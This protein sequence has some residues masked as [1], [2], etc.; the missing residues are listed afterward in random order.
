MEHKNDCIICGK[1]PVYQKSSE[2]IGC[3][4]CKAL[5]PVPVKEPENLVTYDPDKLPYEKR[6]LCIYM[7]ELLD[8]AEKT[9]QDS[10]PEQ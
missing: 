7:R 9:S 4:Y 10:S 6:H 1:E 5:K 3:Y 2:E 8:E